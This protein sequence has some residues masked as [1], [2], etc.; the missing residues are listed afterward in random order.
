M[1]PEAGDN[2]PRDRHRRES[3]IRP[4]E[5]PACTLRIRSG[6]TDPGYNSLHFALACA[7]AL[8]APFG[9]GSNFEHR[10]LH[11]LERVWTE[12]PLYFI[13]CCTIQRRRAL[14]TDEAVSVLKEVWLNAE[15]LY[16]W[17][18]G[19]YVVMPDHL[20]FFAAPNPIAKPLPMFVG[21][22]KEWTAKYLHQRLGIATPLWQPEFFD[23]LLRSTESYAE[24]WHYVRHN[25][26]RAG[27][28]TEPEAWPYWGVMN[29]MC[30]P[31]AKH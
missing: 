6:V 19:A 12:A 17:K 9:M 5:S 10:H 7:T 31:S 18:V 21:K 15:Q 22:W 30:P 29:E 8:D 2:A 3:W 14:A 24:K 25:P 4:I 28:V 16:G 23:H 1:S 11:R 26:V 20:H 13:T 27:L